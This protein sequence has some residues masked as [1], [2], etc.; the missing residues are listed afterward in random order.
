M[1]YTWVLWCV[2]YITRLLDLANPWL[3]GQEY[4]PACLPALYKLFISLAPTFL[5][6]FPI[7]CFKK[8][9]WG[10]G[11]WNRV[12]EGGCVFLTF[13]FKQLCLL[14]LKLTQRVAAFLALVPKH[15]QKL[16]NSCTFPLSQYP[17]SETSKNWIF[18]PL[19]PPLFPVLKYLFPNNNKMQKVSRKRQADIFK[20]IKKIVI[21]LNYIYLFLI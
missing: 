6:P 21:S 2:F 8:G 18:D 10:R 9:R 11:E 20:N 13:I 19:S 14:Y 4:V 1:K 12:W 3:A 7:V 15:S 16:L 5:L 17:R